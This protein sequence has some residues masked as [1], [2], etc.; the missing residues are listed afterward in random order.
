MLKALPTLGGSFGQEGLNGARGVFCGENMHR[1]CSP[2]L[3]LLTFGRLCK[4]KG[5]EPRGFEARGRSILT[6]RVSLY[7]VNLGLQGG[8]SCYSFLTSKEKHHFTPCPWRIEP[9]LLPCLGCPRLRVGNY[10]CL[11]GEPAHIAHREVS[12]RTATVEVAGALCSP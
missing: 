6:Y 11:N 1:S 9:L 2:D 10:D 3:L 8:Y 7:L 4:L 5:N 12:S